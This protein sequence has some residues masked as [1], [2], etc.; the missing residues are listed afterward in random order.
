MARFEEDSME[1]L[2][3]QLD[4]LRRELIA[5]EEHYNEARTQG[6]RR[7]MVQLEG[8]LDRLNLAITGLLERMSQTKE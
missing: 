5:T 2:Q 6:K 8:D 3:A 4:R 1:D 7:D